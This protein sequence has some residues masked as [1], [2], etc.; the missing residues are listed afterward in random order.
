MTLP[1]TIHRELAF[2]LSQRSTLLLL[3]FVTCCAAFTV[4]S[5]LREIDQ[6]RQAIDQLRAE[7]RIE[8]ESAIA[9]QSDYGEAAYYSFHL[10]YHP[11]SDSAFLAFGQRDDH[12]WKH[13]IRM[14]ALEGQIYESDTGNPA[15]AISGTFD[16]LFL[17][18]VLLPLFA[19]VLLYDLFASEHAAGR[20]HLL[21][22]TSG[23]D[24][25]LWR[26]RALVRATLLALAVLVPMWFGSLA[27]DTGVETV[28]LI[29]LVVI[30]H[31]IFWSV[32]AYWCASRTNSGPVIATQ[33][34]GFWVVLA[35]LVPFVGG[36][37][38]TTLVAAPESSEIVL[39]QREVVNGAWDL[40]K[41]Q[42]MH[43]FVDRHPEWRGK[44][45]IRAPFEWK[46]Y[47]A[48][49]QVGDESVEELSLARRQSM[50]TRHEVAGYLAL[51]SPPLLTQHLLGR[52]TETDI[53]AALRYD[54]AVRDFHVNL[55]NF[56]YPLLFNDTPFDLETLAEVPAYTGVDDSP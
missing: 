29:S 19:I 52:I 30:G 40:P 50:A 32:L 36:G 15:L 18:S 53:I 45:E 1:Q 9:N 28:L 43:A 24:R 13:R 54:Q 7:D 3:A 21:A 38:I 20:Y 14:L 47:Y 8:R 49:Q 35:L 34:L 11:P 27:A 17:T 41:D 51:L 37:A 2:L 6:Q 23:D 5:G 12:T 46:W 44:T 33:L 4:W 25:R 56:Y 42:T 16:Y 10:T 55:R 39:G 48:F 31:L 22:A 26:M